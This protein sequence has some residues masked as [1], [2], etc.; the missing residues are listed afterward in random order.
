MVPSHADVCRVNPSPNPNSI[1]NCKKLGNRALRHLARCSFLVNLRA[2]GNGRFSGPGVQSLVQGAR[3]LRSIALER[4][5]R[6]DDRAMAALARLPVV[7]IDLAS[8]PGI[9]D[10]SVR[11]DGFWEDHAWGSLSI[12]L[13]RSAP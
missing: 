6:L 11:V 7:S 10:T 1:S 12:N 9:T 13:C 3:G 2:C 4:S 5:S 8:C